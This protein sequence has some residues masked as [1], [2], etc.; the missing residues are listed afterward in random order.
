MVSVVRLGLIDAMNL[1]P[2]NDRDIKGVQWCH[3]WFS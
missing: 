1:S 2:E 3:V